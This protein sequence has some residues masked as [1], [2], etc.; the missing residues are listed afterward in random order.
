MRPTRLD[1][2]LLATLVVPT[3]E[4][5][6]WETSAVSLTITNIIASVFIAAFVLDRLARRDPRL[7]T[8]SIAL[9]GF[10]LAFAAVY[11]AGYWDLRDRDA[12]AFWVKGIVTWSVHFAFLVCATAH[13]VRRGRELFVR[14]IWAFVGGMLVNCV[15]GAVQLT[16]QV[17]AG[18]NLDTLV[19]GPLTAGQGKQGGIGVFGQV[20]G[21]QTVYRINALTGDPN[22]LG[23]M[24]CVPLFLVFA[25]YLR[26]R[27]ARRWAVAALVL[28][29]AVQALTLSRSAA[30]G[31]V[32]GLLA[33]LPGLR[34]HLPSARRMAIGAGVILAAGLA[35]YASSH[36]VQ[37]VISARTQLSGSGVLT[38]LQFYQLV[39]P[40]LNP[41]PLFGMGF[42]T[43]AVF[44][45]FLT[46]RTDYGPHSSWIATLV[47]TGVVGFTLYLVYF[48]WLLGNALRLR[49]A[50]DP[51]IGRFG[52]GIAAA[53]A[54][55]AAA[56][57][58]YLTMTLEY[59]FV[60]ALLAVAGAALFAPEPAPVAR[61]AS[62]G[63]LA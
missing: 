28:M 46:G 7:P 6:R 14:C 20:G 41:N 56:N 51:D 31:D 55:T 19:V 34:G 27:R 40:A 54:G 59:F 57:L 29:L 39:P 22:H 36:F 53:L 32:V 17:G 11:L 50:A 24:L 62:L 43:F 60:V 25:W 12:L 48:A 52:W 8:A 44:Y 26:G 37:T 42:N 63:S 9:L 5:I 30:L 21:E 16:L 38:H 1:W 2:L 61:T 13:V 10:M 33:L 58:F 45:E 35:V 15:Y 49:L 47:E 4:K 23:V 18:I 3:W